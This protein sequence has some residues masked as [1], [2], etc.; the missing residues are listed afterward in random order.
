MVVVSIGSIA[1]TEP[2]MKSEEAGE[3]AWGRASTWLQ[4][5]ESEVEGLRAV[6]MLGSDAPLVPAFFVVEGKESGLDIAFG[7]GAPAQGSLPLYR[8]SRS[9]PI[10]QWR[11]YGT[12]SRHPRTP[13]SPSG[14]Q[15]GPGQI[16]RIPVTLCC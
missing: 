7:V 15:S 4:P 5:C 10:A 1:M 2:A 8:A 13:L 14:R 9:Y 12:G 11:E 16:R 6:A 3:S